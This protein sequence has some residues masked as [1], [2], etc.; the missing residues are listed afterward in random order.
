MPPASA[1]GICFAGEKREQGCRN[2]RAENKKIDTSEKDFEV[3]TQVKDAVCMIDIEKNELIYMNE[4]AKNISRKFLADGNYVGKKCYEVLHGQKTVCSFCQ[5]KL[6]SQE[7]FLLEEVYQPFLKRYLQLK[8]I[9]VCTNNKKVRFQVLSVINSETIKLEEKRIYEKL[10]EMRRTD[11]LT[12]VFN[13]SY[14]EEV[15]ESIAND[16]PETL[17]VTVIN[18]NEMKRINDQYGSVFGDAILKEVG[19]SLLEVF[20]GH[21]FRIDGDEFVVLSINQTKAEFEQ[22]LK[23]FKEKIKAIKNVSTAVGS[24]WKSTGLD[25]QKQFMTANKKVKE[26][27]DT[28]HTHL[29]SIDRKYFKAAKKLL[30]EI[31]KRMFT[32]YLQPKINLSD[33][34]L[35]GA[36]ALVRK[37]NG[38]GNLVPPIDFIPELEQN[39]LICFVDF[40]VLETVCEYIHNWQKHGK[41]FIKVSV[42]MSR[43]TL[44]KKNVVQKAVA[45]CSKYQIEPQMIEIEI[46]ESIG[47]LE[48]KLITRLMDDFHAAG[49]SI[50]LDDFGSGFSNIAALAEN[51]FDV[52]KIDK[53]LI[54]TIFEN[55]KSRTVIQQAINL[56][57][58]VNKNIETV[59]EGVET[60]QQLQILK[61]YGCDIGQGYLFSRPIPEEKFLKYFLTGEN[62]EKCD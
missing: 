10:E 42:N 47:G 39:G 7:G 28:Y 25:M 16:L 31:H 29:H 3:Y 5:N 37:L 6:L 12:G 59:G 35:N 22:A 40:F 20:E 8:S 34:K 33:E 55:D 41:K 49:F 9:L 2:E 51:D 62:G 24:S 48:K 21:C 56:C 4:E 23:T 18:I 13:R 50:A 36:E 54:D 27:K 46:T 60:E 43:T 44:R 1:G 30:Q 15:A 58:A 53:S 14:Y 32:V 52:V 26:V 17:G 19:K 61:E 38:K 11:M 57:N 45:I